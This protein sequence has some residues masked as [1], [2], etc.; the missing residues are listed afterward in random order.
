MPRKPQH[1]PPTSAKSA[2]PQ[3]P[4]SED[5]A[6]PVDP[7]ALSQLIEHVARLLAQDYVAALKRGLE[8]DPR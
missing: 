7:E 2:A 5:A 6:T 4:I 3:L 8:A 1:T